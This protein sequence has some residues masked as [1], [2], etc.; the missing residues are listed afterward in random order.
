[1]QC[2]N[3]NEMWKNLKQIVLLLAFKCEEHNIF[4]LFNEGD[5]T[6]KQNICDI[7]IIIFFLC[8]E[9]Q[10]RISLIVHRYLIVCVMLFAFRVFCLISY[11][12]SQ[13]WLSLTPK[14]LI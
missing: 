11:P 9:R 12:G 4:K 8:S 10:V 13:Q 7:N 6:I 2:K 3:G 14:S 5:K 1:M